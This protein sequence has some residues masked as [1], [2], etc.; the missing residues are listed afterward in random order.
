MVKLTNTQITIIIIVVIIAIVLLIYFFIN[1]PDNEQ[2]TPLYTPCPNENYINHNG[3]CDCNQ[4]TL[5]CMD[6]NQNVYKVLKRDA[7]NKCEFPAC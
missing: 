4:D 3:N 5:N 2:P 6:K 1:K 7:N